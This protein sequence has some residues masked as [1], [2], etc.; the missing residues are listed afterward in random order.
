MKKPVALAFA[1]AVLLNLFYN[2]TLPLHFDEA[3]YWVWSKHL[4]FSYFDHP[5]LIAWLIR[6]AT[7]A[8]DSEFWIRL[9]PLGCSAL[10]GYGIWRLAAD[11]FDA[12][13]ADRALLL[14]L[15]SPLAQIG[16]SLA[17]PDSPLILAW[18][19]SLLFFSRA[20]FAG[21]PGNYFWAGLC[22]G[23]ALLSKYT[24]VLL[25]PAF[26][27]FLIL[28][29]RLK[30]L[31]RKEI[32]L[33][34][35]L[36]V[37]VFL[38]VI[39]WNAL[40]QWS[41][42]AFQLQHGFAGPRVINPRTFLEYLAVQ[43]AGLNPLF[44]LLLLFL[45]LRHGRQMLQDPKQLFLFCSWG[46]VLLFFGYAA[47][48][49]RA[50]GNWAAPAHVGGIILLAR[51]LQPP[52]YQFLYRTGIVL[53]LAL[54]MLLKTPEWFAGL[55]A[56][57]VL[58]NQV[59]GYD[60]MFQSAGDRVRTGDAVWAADYK[61]ASLARYYLPGRPEVKVLSPSRISQYDYWQDENKPSGVA[62]VYFGYPGH[63]PV[64]QQACIT[65]EELPSLQYQ[66]RY[67]NRT[68]KGYRCKSR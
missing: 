20:V 39:Y 18:T 56:K 42:F 5:P 11:L 9:V 34:L 40:H 60:V 21:K 43:A 26:L 13:T 49:K 17:T 51:W 41:S 28:A 38:P 12:A 47:L 15:L 35:L 63:L 36:T 61:L 44:F 57:L 19:A 62:W 7:I 50:E 65:V 23:L 31:R 54:T 53:G 2:S 29:G 32:W 48:F 30:E 14:F 33:G 16:F 46:T 8:G 22:G 64:L 67:V 66:D 27:L 25:A 52:S 55:P 59:I 3:Y 10:T 24:A 45:I 58:K 4:Q 6:L 1:L 68:L 37:T